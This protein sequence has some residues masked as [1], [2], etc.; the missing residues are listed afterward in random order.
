MQIQAVYGAKM[1]AEQ[2]RADASPQVP[3]P[4]GNE[5]MKEWRITK[6]HFTQK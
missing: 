6:A 1:A 5:R 2:H 3:A 4:R